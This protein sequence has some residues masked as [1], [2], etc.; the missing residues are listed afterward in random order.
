MNHEDRAELRV[1]RATLVGLK[2]V[3]LEAGAQI[4]DSRVGTTALADQI[5]ATILG[6]D[7]DGWSPTRAMAL[8]AQV[9]SLINRMDASLAANTE[10][11]RENDEEVDRINQRLAEG[12]SE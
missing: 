5:E 12:D 6:G 3:M 2:A 9:H 8:L 4:T 10:A 1:N 7:L 11:I